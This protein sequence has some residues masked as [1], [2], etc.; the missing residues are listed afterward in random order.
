MP[1]GIDVEGALPVDELQP[2]D[3]RGVGDARVRD[4][5]IDPAVGDDRLLEGPAD[6]VF[7]RDVHLDADRPIDPVPL[8]EGSR[9]LPRSFDRDIGGDHMAPLG[10]EAAG[11]GA[12]EAA[13]GA[14]HDRHAPR[15]VPLGR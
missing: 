12:A 13:G 11:D 8:A 1:R 3:G 2:V 5:D 14:G 7:A 6:A 9:Q 10:G 4:Q 15:Q